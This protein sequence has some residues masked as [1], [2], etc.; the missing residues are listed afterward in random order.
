MSMPELYDGDVVFTRS[1][2]QHFFADDGRVIQANFSSG[3]KHKFVMV[4]IGTVEDGKE[5]D[6]DLEA[7]LKKHGLM[8]IPTTE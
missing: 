3:R 1:I 7:M 6:I 5:T 8:Q 4:L 2:K